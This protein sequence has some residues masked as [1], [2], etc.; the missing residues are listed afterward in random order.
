MIV[1]C[2]FLVL[3]NYNHAFSHNTCPC[4]T[5][6]NQHQ[7]FT[8]ELKEEEKEEEEVSWWQFASGLTVQQLENGD[9]TCDWD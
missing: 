8:G 1:F 6:S 7:T 4:I 3:L 5:P 2:Y 9:F